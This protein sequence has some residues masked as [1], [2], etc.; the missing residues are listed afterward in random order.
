MSRQVTYA[1]INDQV[2]AKQKY[3]AQGHRQN[4]HSIVKTSSRLAR[5]LL[6]RLTA[7]CR[8]AIPLS[9]SW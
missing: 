2:V 1:K 6:G 4:S 7:D 5:L 9:E 3:A 8:V